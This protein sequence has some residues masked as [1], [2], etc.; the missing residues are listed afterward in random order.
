MIFQGTRCV[1]LFDWELAHL[2]NPIDD[3]CWY[4]ML[5]RCLGEGIDLPRLSGFLDREETVAYWEKVSGM[6][7]ANFEYYELFAVYRFSVIMYRIISLY[8]ETGAWPAY[9]DFDVNNLATNILEKEMAKR[10]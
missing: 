9:S 8:K 3:V 7:A 1:G 4:L 2:G 10:R 6:Q 5:D